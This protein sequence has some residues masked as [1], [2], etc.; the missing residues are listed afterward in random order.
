MIMKCPKC[1]SFSYRDSYCF[2]CGYKSDTRKS[3][4]F[5]YKKSPIVNAGSTPSRFDISPFYDNTHTH[6]FSSHDYGS[7]S[8]SH[9]SSSSDSSSSDSSSCD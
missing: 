4:E 6:D 3:L 8:H 1:R 2:S 9:S 7:S 5:L